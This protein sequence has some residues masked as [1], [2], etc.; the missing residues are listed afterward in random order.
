LDAQGVSY[1]G[2][3]DLLT[4]C[5]LTADSLNLSPSQHTEPLFRKILGGCRAV[6]D[7]VDALT[8]PRTDAHGAAPTGLR[9]ATRHAELAVNLAGT[10]ATFL[11][12]TWDSKRR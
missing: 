7:G 9:P 12:A 8:H 2:T 3:D 1:T 5:R 6:I 10:V 4:L 11:L